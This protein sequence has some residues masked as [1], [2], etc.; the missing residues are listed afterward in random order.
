MHKTSSDDISGVA[1]EVG[2]LQW[3]EPLTVGVK[4]A[5]PWKDVKVPE[6]SK[7]VTVQEI[8]MDR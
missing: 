3:R 8:E 2:G 7:C 6:I 1:L 5:P 4:M